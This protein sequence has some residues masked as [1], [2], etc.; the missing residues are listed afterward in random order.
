MMLFPDRDDDL[1][2]VR[3]LSK[4]NK[5]LPPRPSS[6]V[7]PNATLLTIEKGL[8]DLSIELV[9]ATTGMSTG[10]N[11]VPGTGTPAS[12]ASS[13]ASSNVLNEKNL[14]LDVRTRWKAKMD[15]TTIRLSKD[16]VRYKND[17]TICSSSGLKQSRNFVEF[18]LSTKIYLFC[19]DGSMFSHLK[20]QDNSHGRPF[21]R[22]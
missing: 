14:P 8:K 19:L 20:F 12:T 13:N 3:D 5:E 21:L 16:R 22:I 18:P 11:T 10:T 17:L 1:I 9:K 15:S 4:I 2:D 6:A 7:T